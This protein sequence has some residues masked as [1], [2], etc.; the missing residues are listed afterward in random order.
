MSDLTAII[1]ITDRDARDTEMYAIL[2]ISAPGAY[3]MREP[4]GRLMVWAS[5]SDSIDDDGARATYRSSGPIA[6]AE[7]TE[8]TRLA[9]IDEYEG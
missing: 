3:A 6:D 2:G 4:D 5:E 8:V 7:W 1:T 9:W